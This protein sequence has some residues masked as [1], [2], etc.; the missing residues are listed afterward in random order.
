MYWNDKAEGF[1]IKYSSD[2]TISLA[3]SSLVVLDKRVCIDRIEF[4]MDASQSPLRECNSR[5]RIVYEYQGTPG[6]AYA[7]LEENVMKIDFTGCELEASEEVLKLEIKGSPLGDVYE[8]WAPV[9]RIPC[10]YDRTG[11]P[12]AHVSG[13]IK[14]IDTTAYEETEYITEYLASANAAQAYP[15]TEYMDVDR[16]GEDHKPY[17]RNQVQSVHALSSTT[18]YAQPDPA[19][20]QDEYYTYFPSSVPYSDS[21]LRW[22][23]YDGAKR[24]ESINEL[25]LDF[26][27][28]LTPGKMLILN[29]LYIATPGMSLD[30][31]E[32]IANIYVDEKLIGRVIC[33]KAISDD[34]REMDMC[35]VVDLVQTGIAKTLRT[36]KNKKFMVIFTKRTGGRTSFTVYLDNRH[37]PTL[38]LNGELID[39]IDDS[40]KYYYHPDHNKNIIAQ[41]NAT[42]DLIATWD[43]DAFGNITSQTGTTASKN[44]FRFSSEYHDENLGLI[45]YNYRHYNPRDGR[46][47]S[48]DPIGEEGGVNLYGFV[49]NNLLNVIDKLGL[50]LELYTKDVS[51]IP[52]LPLKVDEKIPGVSNKVM[53]KSNGGITYTYFDFGGYIETKRFKSIITS[54]EYILYKPV[55]KG[56][57][58][59]AIY[60]NK[61]IFK[62]GNETVLSSANQVYTL[63]RVWIHEKRHAAFSKD[64]WNRY[65]E[66]LS[67]FEKFYCSS[68]CATLMYKIM[69]NVMRYAH[70][71]NAHNNALYD[72]SNYPNGYKS[73][74]LVE[75]GKFSLYIE[76]LVG[77]YNK[78]KCKY[79]IEPTLGLENEFEELKLEDLGVI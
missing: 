6:T 14:N 57:L 67:K 23:M 62:T 25:D 71:M 64:A 46:W 2:N 18:A 8:S 16:A 3:L 78:G 54:G 34:D 38:Q 26:N 11:R 63:N 70:F 73:E 53:E 32:L 74:Y 77:I 43:Y 61:T 37:R 75:A 31:G 47:I 72:K 45:Y 40:E 27:G 19:M 7:E 59:M 41:S 33:D 69:E 13:I 60:Y 52:M 76:Y 44:P 28:E 22:E 50:E 12:L 5:Y 17:L 55:L 49:G 10:Y 1:H 21:L 9:T 48:R 30:V 29:A 39:E 66:I 68:P 20:I 65:A 35:I 79:V 51:S 24:T 36:M 58:D 56:S 15:W 4:A 42:G